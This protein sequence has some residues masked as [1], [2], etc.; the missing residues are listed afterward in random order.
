MSSDLYQTPSGDAQF[1][2]YCGGNL[3]S[4]NES[5]VEIAQLPGSSSATPRRTDQAV[6][7][8]SPSRNST[9]SPSVTP[10]SAA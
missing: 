8:G 5:C 10:R 9:T 3:Q 7:C 2:R 6:S 1:T 4:E